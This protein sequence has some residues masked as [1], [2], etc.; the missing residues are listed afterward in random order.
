MVVG[1]RLLRFN[2]QSRQNCDKMVVTH[3][4]VSLVT[5]FQETLGEN[6]KH[7]FEAEDSVSWE[8]Y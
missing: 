5:A 7:A 4:S 3:M 2:Q 8:M 6:C 1:L